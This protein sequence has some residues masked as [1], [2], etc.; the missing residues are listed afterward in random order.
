MK[1]RII[2]ISIVGIILLGTFNILS[3]NNSKI[4]V[5]SKVIKEISSLVYTKEEREIGIDRLT[6]LLEDKKYLSKRNKV[7]LISKLGLLYSM[8]GEYHEAIEHFIESIN[9]SMKYDDNYRMAKDLMNMAHIFVNLDG[10]K[11]A[12]RTIKYALNLDIE[13]EEEKRVINEYGYINLADI[14]SRIDETDKSLEYI[15]KSIK[16]GTSHKANTI[17]RKIIEARSYFYKGEITKADEILSEINIDKDI[18]D[19]VLIDTYIPYLAVRTKIEFAKGNEGKA[20]ELSEKL[21]DI[22]D[23]EGQIDIKLSNMKYLLNYL[24]SPDYK[25][26]DEIITHYRQELIDLYNEISPEKNEES[27]FYIINSIWDRMHYLESLE[28]KAMM[29]IGAGFM[30][31]I[32]ILVFYILISRLKNS[33][34]KSRVDALTNIYNRMF[35]DLTY[36]KYLKKGIGFGLIIIDIDFFKSINDTYGHA[37]GDIVLKNVAKVIKNRLSKDDIIFR[38][39]GEEFC[40]LSENK[41]LQEVIDLSELIR[42]EVERMVWREN[43]KVTISLGISYTGESDDMFKQADSNLY[44]SKNSGRNRVTY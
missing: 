30:T 39:G 23:K 43:I 38:Y 27:V 7:E 24:E 17:A 14:Y 4:E 25:Y 41:G 15:E 10:Y 11:T 28:T 40:I 36:N 18:D 31:L 6:T 26:D 35:F 33:I 3:K 21:F 1:N 42:E 5:N 34:N 2:V 9:L 16:Y 32:L 22:C 12:E 8:N 37:F 13:D 20:F 44:K 29:Y 19:Y